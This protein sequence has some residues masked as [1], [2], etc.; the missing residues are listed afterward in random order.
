MKM[1]GMGDIFLDK[2]VF[3]QYS[4]VDAVLYDFTNNDLIHYLS[5]TNERISNMLFRTEKGIVDRKLSKNKG[6]KEFDVPVPRHEEFLNK[7][8]SFPFVKFLPF[9]TILTDFGCP[10]SCSFCVYSEIG[11]KTGNLDR[12]FDE[13][14]YIKKLGIREIFFKD[15]TFCIQPKRAE[16][17]CAYMIDN[18][19][20]FSWTCFLRVTQAKPD[21]LS[22][23]KRAGCHTIIFG[24]ETASQDLLD[25]YLKQTSLEDIHKA[26]Q[27]CRKFGLKSVCTFII[28]FPDESIE[29]MKKTID[30]SIDLNPNYAAFNT[31]VRKTESMGFGDQIDKIKDQS[32]IQNFDVKDN[33]SLS[34]QEIQTLRKSAIKKFYFRPSYIKQELSSIRSYTEFKSKLKAFLFLLK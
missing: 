17:I 21:F 28:G 4:W 34:G 22:L 24:V 7:N 1:I 10:F 14:Q 9:V 27:I 8:Y 23:L 20:R 30:F 33:D 31:Y 6:E 29:S 32:G 19:M 12:V 18:K 16:K 11:Y 15:Q 13:L 26:I 25:Q 5:N 3:S 2:R